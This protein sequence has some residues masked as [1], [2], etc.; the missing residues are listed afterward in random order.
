M[1]WAALS[2]GFILT[3]LALGVYISFR[4]FD[5]VDLTADG[6]IAL[7]AGVCAVLL[8]AGWHPAAATL[9]APLV[10][11]AAGAV[12]GALATKCR[13]NKLLAGILT[14]TALYS[15]NL[16]ILGRGSVSLAGGLFGKAGAR[17][18][19]V[20]ALGV[21][22]LVSLLLFLF[23]R[24]NLGTAMR[25]SG[26]NAQAVRALGADDGTLTIL[27]L[28]LSNGL[29]ALAGALLA[30]LLGFADVHMGLGML[31]WG[32]AAVLI[33]G[34]LVGTRR[35]GPAIAGAAAGSVLFCLLAVGA[36]GWGLNPND[37]KLAAAG[38]VCVA[39]ILPKVRLRKGRL[40]H[41]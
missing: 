35:L 3:L 33:G 28:A 10:G 1:I 19:A 15:V 21:A 39:L 9:A 27:G 12:T 17:D 20:L 34:A 13:V 23:F 6:S 32:L 26:G 7:G 38:F 8:A 11:M 31:V 36:L 37:V 14:M 5:F 22:V 41:A 4:V 2:A 40:A 29:I 25:A 16:R 30:Q 18:A 24:T